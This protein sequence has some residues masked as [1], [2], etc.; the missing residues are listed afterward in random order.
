MEDQIIVFGR[1]DVEQLALSN[2][3]SKCLPTLLDFKSN[4]KALPYIQEGIKTIR[5]GGNRMAIL[6]HSNNLLLTL[7]D[8]KVNTTKSSSS[9][10]HS[11]KASIDVPSHDICL[12]RNNVIDVAVGFSHCLF[13]TKQHEL[14]G[15]GNTSN[16][17]IGISNDQMMDN[18]EAVITN[19]FKR[20]YNIKCYQVPLAH[21]LDDHEHVTSIFALGQGTICKTNLENLISF[22]WNYRGELCSGVKS[23]RQGPKKI[24]FFNSSVIDGIYTGYSHVMFLVNKRTDPKL[25]VCGWNESYQLGLGHNSNVFSITENEYCTFRHEIID[26]A[27]GYDFSIF[28]TRHGR[29]YGCGKLPSSPSDTIKTFGSFYEFK[30]DNITQITCG[31]YHALFVV[32]HKQIF[33]SGTN[34]C[35]QCGFS[36][37]DE[38]NYGISNCRPLNISNPQPLSLLSAGQYC[39]AIL[40]SCGHVKYEA[41][42]RMKERLLLAVDESKLIDMIIR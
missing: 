19:T 27:L 22:G 18:E 17:R 3:S 24:T 35:C 20:L 26:I 41:E 23:D 7:H 16:G 39:S 28:L 38:T 13:L 25:Y 42:K 14:Y 31:Y 36:D 37:E 9:T 34:D 10:E 12:L 32:N 11:N 8:Y 6:T 21:L 40:F 15:F 4:T 2:R 5:Q 29:V 1:N 30:L 33:A